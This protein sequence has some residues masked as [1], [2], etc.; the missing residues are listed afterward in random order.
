MAF[1]SSEKIEAEQ[2]A[3]NLISNFDTER[4]RYG[5]Y[6][7]KLSTE[8]L[9]TPDGKTDVSKPGEGT[10][11]KIPP[12]QF[13][14]LFA[15]E[16]IKIPHNAIGFISLKT[17]E[18]M[19]GLVNVSGFHV[20]PGFHGH[21]KFSVYNAGNSCI[22]IDY[23]SE[24]FLL[25]FCDLDRTSAQTWD[26]TNK[27]QKA[28]ITAADYEQMSDRRHSPAML[29]NRLIKLEENVDLIKSVGVV[30]VFPMLIGFA[31]PVFEHLLGS[32]TD[33]VTNNELIIG[34]SLVTSLVIVIFLAIRNYCTKRK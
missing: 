21:L 17:S 26:K 19:K 24:C 30:I 18:K 14:L 9:V 20:D 29:H 28:S 16:S 33:K 6:S 2:K 15:L 8:V 10:H 4:L 22:C 31:V 27:I 3:N 5:R 25:W 7:L 11:V 1:W 34:V 23:N 13:A 32:S 12:G